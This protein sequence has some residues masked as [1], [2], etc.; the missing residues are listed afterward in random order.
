MNKEQ[1]KTGKVYLVGAGPGD[2]GLLTVK[3]MHTIAA[4]DIIIYD[5]L[6]SP[7]LL[8]YARFGAE[9][10]YVGKLPQR[11]T[12]KQE[13]INELIVQKALEGHTVVRL[14]GGD[15]YLF[16]RGGEEAE[17]LVENGVSF[18]IVPGITSAIAVPAYA[19]IPVT[20]R[21]F[22]SSFAVITGHEDPAKH[23]TSVAW[24]KLAT[25]IGTLVFLMGVGNLPFIMQKLMEGGRAPDTPVALVR[26]G[27]RP[28]QATLTGQ[29][30]NIVKKVQ[31]ADFHS[32]A[33]IIVGEVVSLREKLKWFE[34]KPLFGKR[35]VVTRSR[36]QAS[37]L[38]QRIEELG[39]DPLEFP[40]I[41]IVPP[42]DYT[43]MDRA[44]DGISS[45]HWL[46]FTSVNGVES[47]FDR[48]RYQQKDIR[49]LKGLRLCAIGPKTKEALE[50]KGLIVD[51]M[52]SEYRAEAIIENLKGVLKPGEKVLL[53][54]ADIARKILSETL[55]AMGAEV[56]SVEA[57]RTLQGA[58]DAVHLREMLR[59]K[60]IHIVT[61]TSSST[62]RN[63]V[64]LLGEDS[65]EL[66]AGVTLASIGPI[67]T[68]TAKKLGLKIDLEARE[69]TIEG[70]LQG[71]VDYCIN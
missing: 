34:N 57:Y 71:I 1:S 55:T 42:A 28:E 25:G 60:L 21:D 69:Y 40:V 47:F 43:P 5:R 62:V 8:S 22:T 24:D 39:G 61:F 18:E 11:H 7:R 15:P 64:E 46:I 23:E 63:F 58:G 52:P 2:P 10:I 20:H 30:D 26:W 49:D 6:V 13:E 65:K 31:E 14:K 36:S 67:T 9:L 53:P 4:A 32:P 17:L 44:I 56:D 51:Y 19:G 70:L 3:G 29:L 33:V 66:L 27:T 35:V 68:S 38:S 48:L 41:E 59:D 45:Y 16:G 37:V 12:L 54:R 50:E